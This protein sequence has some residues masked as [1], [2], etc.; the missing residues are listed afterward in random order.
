MR[1]SFHSF[2]TGPEEHDPTGSHGTMQDSV[3]DVVHRILAPEVACVIRIKSSN[4]PCGQLQH[5]SLASNLL[6]SFIRPSNVILLLRDSD[7][8]PAPG[9]R[10]YPPGGPDDHPN[11]LLHIALL[12]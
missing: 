1:T 5:P 3:A 10:Q 8:C 7:R 2:S 4:G 9:V 12:G 6:Y 11:T